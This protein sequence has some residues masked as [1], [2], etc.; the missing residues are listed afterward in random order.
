MTTAT[1][2]PA[3]VRVSLWMKPRPTIGGW[4]NDVMRIVRKTV[5]EELRAGRDQNSFAAASPWLNQS[6]AQAYLK[7][8]RTTLFDRRTARK[9]AKTTDAK[10]RA[11][12]PDHGRG[13]SLRFHRDD[14]DAWMARQRSD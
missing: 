13:T 3:P 2:K 11:F 9:L 8:S 7:M 4:L 10:A 1:Q 12:A 6:E 5:R 14:L